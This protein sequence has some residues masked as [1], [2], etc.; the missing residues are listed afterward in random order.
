MPRV[1]LMDF[2]ERRFVFQP[3]IRWVYKVL[4]IGFQ[5]IVDGFPIGFLIDYKSILNESKMCN[6]LPNDY[7]WASK[8]FPVGSQQS[9]LIMSQRIINGF[10]MDSDWRTPWIPKGFSIP[11]DFL[12]DFQRILLRFLNG[13]LGGFP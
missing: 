4:F 1:Y 2:Q 9:F 11:N 3:E 10:P 6:Q 8:I 7:Y 5:Q 12:M 13:F